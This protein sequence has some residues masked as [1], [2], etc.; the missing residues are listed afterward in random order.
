[1]NTP[2]Q[3]SN[4]TGEI[5]LAGRYTPWG[6][7][8][9]VHGT[10]SFTFGYLGGMMDLASGLIYVGNGQYYDPST[11]RFLSRGVN[12]NGTNPYVPWNPVGAIIGPLSL[13]SL[14]AVRRR[15]KLGK[16][17][18]Y[19]LMLLILIVLPLSVGMACEGEGGVT[20]TEPVNLTA[21]I[22]NGIVTSTAAVAGQTITTTAPISTPIYACNIISYA[23]PND[24]EIS[25][26][27]D[28]LV[29]YIRENNQKSP[30]Y[31][32]VRDYLKRL[33]EEAGRQ[34]LNTNHLAYI[35]ATTH[36]ESGW[37]DFQEQYDSISDFDKYE[38][39][40][41]LGEQ[42]GN[43]QKGDG[44]RYKGRGFIHL[45]GRGNYKKVSEYLNLYVYGSD[46]VTRLPE[47]EQYPDRANYG[48]GVNGY[49]YITQIAVKGIT[50]QTEVTIFTAPGQLLIGLKKGGSPQGIWAK[51]LL[52]F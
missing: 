32:A 16:G 43:T 8:L 1:L 17:H 25:A 15:G 4:L 5:T 2:R 50:D 30:D 6:D 39:G 46:G 31:G 19:L 36:V 40:T 10:G 41:I 38:P 44:E 42:L 33:M 27:I 51:D 37:V 21:T 29:N 35:Y 20:P 49:D 26:T 34:G 14:I 7:I 22:D 11:G 12:P 48:P 18:G 3:L 9:E 52:T 23:G 28:D 45:T 47:L 13:F 24:T